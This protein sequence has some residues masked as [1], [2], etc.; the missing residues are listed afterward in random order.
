VCVRSIEGVC[1]VVEYGE[2]WICRANKI[3][4]RSKMYRL[5]MGVHMG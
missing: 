3:V 1:V 4:G 2:S 5:I